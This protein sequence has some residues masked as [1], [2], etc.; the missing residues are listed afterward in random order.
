MRCEFR[1]WRVLYRR[2]GGLG[3]VAALICAAAALATLSGCAGSS[4]NP[5]EFHTSGSREADQRAEQRM[6][7]EAQMRGEAGEA[8]EAGARPPL[9]E[10]LGGAEGVAKIVDDFVVRA[11]ADPRANW[12]RKGVTRGGVLG[13]GGKSAE[14]DPSPASVERLKKRFAQF[15]AVATGGPPEYEGR[16]MEAVHAGMKIDNAEFDA[17]V[18]AL[19]ASLDVLGVGVDEQ[20]ELLAVFESTRPQIAEER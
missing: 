20:K 8:A 10:R 6:T 18:G 19:K 2:A 15:I 4:Q 13:I 5:R 7:R 12:Q 11:M 9:Y 3:R 16:E 14:W 1:R 17:V